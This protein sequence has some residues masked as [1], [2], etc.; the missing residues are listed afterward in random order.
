MEALLKK[1]MN[2]E[3]YVS[4]YTRRNAAGH[5]DYGRLLSISDRHYALYLIAPDGEYD[6]I[7][8][9]T[10]ESVLRVE[11]DGQYQ[12]K[13]EKLCDYANLPAPAFRLDADD[14]VGSILAAAMS[15]GRIA[16][17][18]LNDSDNFDLVG[19]VVSV[20]DGLCRFKQIDAYGAEDGDAFARV[21]DVTQVVYD[22][23]EENRILKLRR[24]K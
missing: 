14:L 15:A 18:E 1:L 8:V 19:F 20:E 7:M 12:A 13:M 24:A 5:F 17:L 16:S 9:S 4:V 11:T 23:H 22:S 6:G 10:I 3:K 2:D 21:A